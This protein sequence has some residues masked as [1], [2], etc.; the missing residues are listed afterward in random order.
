M[1]Q[2]LGLPRGA[3][4]SGTPWVSTGASLVLPG[5]DKWH[6]SRCALGARRGDWRRGAGEARRTTP[7][8]GVGQ[9]DGQVEQ[10]HVPERGQKDVVEHE[11]ACGRGRAQ[12]C[13][14]KANHTITVPG[15]CAM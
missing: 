10:T 9:H 5:N 11:Q 3:R 12:A 15:Q 2:G 6:G 8:R 4:I 14:R 7:R 13:V 1:R